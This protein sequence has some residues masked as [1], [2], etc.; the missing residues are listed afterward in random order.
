MPKVM[1]KNYFLK[2]SFAT[3]KSVTIAKIKAITSRILLVT[4]ILFPF[5]YKNK[6]NTQ[7]HSSCDYHC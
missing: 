2:K 4:I 7:S 5:L 3:I 6:I 1:E